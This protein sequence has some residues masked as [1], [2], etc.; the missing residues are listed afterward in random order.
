MSIRW[1]KTPQGWRHINS[2]DSGLCCE[3]SKR[4][5]LL[6]SLLRSFYFTLL[7]SATFDLKYAPLALRR[8]LLLFSN[9]SLHFT[10]LQ[11]F[12]HLYCLSLGGILLEADLFA[13]F[14]GMEGKWSFIRGIEAKNCSRGTRSC[15]W[16]TSFRL[17]KVVQWCFSA[18]PT[19][20]WCI[21]SAFVFVVATLQVEVET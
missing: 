18:L 14:G 9:N 13:H 19:L 4:S 11:V 15:L 7:D 5:K 17:C 12:L 3:S 8:S 21:L 20:F 16:V 10:V 6:V 2:R 1:P